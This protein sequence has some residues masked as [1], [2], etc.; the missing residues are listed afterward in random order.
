M[1]FLAYGMSEQPH[2]VIT[3]EIPTRSSPPLNPSPL[4]IPRGGASS[5]D[6]A[7]RPCGASILS[8]AKEVI[9]YTLRCCNPRQIFLF[10]FI[11]ARYFDS[12]SQCVEKC[13]IIVL[14]RGIPAE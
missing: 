3:D 12:E 4:P 13:E 5:A 6:T 7:L 2:E 14:A 8:T 11:V 1:I 9:N 10:F